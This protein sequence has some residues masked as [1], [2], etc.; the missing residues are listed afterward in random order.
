MTNGDE[1]PTTWPDDRFDVNWRFDRTGE[2]WT[3]SSMDQQL[4]KGDS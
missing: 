2:S 4:L 3:F 1:V